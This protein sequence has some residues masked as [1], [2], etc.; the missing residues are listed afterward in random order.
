MFV[1]TLKRHQACK[2]F[3]CK[4]VFVFF[5]QFNHVNFMVP[6]HLV[7]QS[8][9]QIKLRLLAVTRLAVPFR[10]EGIVMLSETFFES[11]GKYGHY[12]SPAG[13]SIYTTAWSKGFYS[14]F[15]EHPLHSSQHE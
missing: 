5:N 12:S 10:E 14:V 15:T 6:Q 2:D 8:R 7:T 11:L 9:G 3:L 1:Y 4:P 13:C